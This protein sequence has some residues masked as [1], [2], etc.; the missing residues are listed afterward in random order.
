MEDT[1]C[2]LHTFKDVVFL[3]PVSKIVWATSNALRTELVNLRK[4]DKETT[5][6]T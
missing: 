6:E 2:R 3:G 5:A 1:L 4:V